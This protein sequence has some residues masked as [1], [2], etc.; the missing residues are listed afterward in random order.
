MCLLGTKRQTTALPSAADI[1][2]EM[3]GIQKKYQMSS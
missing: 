3:G 1:D 2:A